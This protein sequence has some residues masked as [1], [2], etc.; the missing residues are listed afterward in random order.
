MIF[1]ALGFFRFR[2]RIGFGLHPAR[3]LE[4][5]EGIFSPGSLGHRDLVVAG[6]Y[7][8]HDAAD[9]IGQ[10]EAVRRVTLHAFPDVGQPAAIGVE[11]VLQ[12]HTRGLALLQVLLERL[13]PLLMFLAADLCSAADAQILQDLGVVVLDLLRRVGI[14]GK[15]T[16]DLEVQVASFVHERRQV[17]SLGQLDDTPAS[18][19]E[20][21]GAPLFLVERLALHRVVGHFLGHVH[22]MNSR[23]DIVQVIA[24]VPGALLIIERA[25]NLAALV[26]VQEPVEQRRRPRLREVLQRDRERRTVASVDRLAVEPDLGITVQLTSSLLSKPRRGA[27]VETHVAL[28]GLG[29]RD[30][31]EVRERDI[32]A[33]VSGE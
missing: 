10:D 22:D 6:Q 8:V 25:S 9:L 23:G 33:A 24:L 18:L 13:G 11:C 27:V 15:A 3:G 30:I 20:T 29:H 32:V 5:D 1:E 12:R 28:T 14:L 21:D 17:P 7:P 16:H 19:V 26:V 2:L 31:V 4:G